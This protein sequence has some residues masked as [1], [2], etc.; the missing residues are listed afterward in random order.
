MKAILLS[1]YYFI[2]GDFYKTIYWARRIPSD[3]KF[4]LGILGKIKFHL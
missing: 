3:T 2:I 4:K 1:Y